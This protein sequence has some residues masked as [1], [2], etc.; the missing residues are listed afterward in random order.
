MSV[1]EIQ[2]PLIKHKLGLMRQKD[3]STKHFRELSSEIGML[4]NL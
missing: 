3:I 1:H 2:H 4:S